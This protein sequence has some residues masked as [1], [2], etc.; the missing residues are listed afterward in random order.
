M[1]TQIWARKKLAGQVLTPEVLGWAEDDGQGFIY[2]AFVKDEPAK[3]PMGWPC[4]NTGNF[5]LGA[6]RYPWPKPRGA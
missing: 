4:R 3:R 5:A 2:M 1:D 6:A